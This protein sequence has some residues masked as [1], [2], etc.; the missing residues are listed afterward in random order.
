MSVRS[1]IILYLLMAFNLLAADQITY[2]EKNDL[3][4]LKVIN[5]KVRYFKEL[6]YPGYGIE[7]NEKKAARTEDLDL[8]LDFNSDDITH[9]K[10]LNYKIKYYNI[11]IDPDIKFKNSSAGILNSPA[12]KIVVQITKDNY[13][14]GYI[15]LG[16]FYFDF[17]MLLSQYN[18]ENVILK[19]GVYSDNKFYGAVC[20]I[21]N[22]KLSVRFENFF[23]D[24]AN[25]PY[26]FS[27]T[28]KK[29]I[30]L[31]Q[32]LH[33]GFI[34]DRVNGK[35]LLFINGR[36][37]NEKFATLDQAAGSEILCPR[38]SRFDGSDLVLFENFFGYVD[39]FRIGKTAN[40]DFKQS[41]DTLSSKVIIESPLISF[42]Y[43]SSYISNIV[44]KVKNNDK[45][46]INIY[47][48]Y[49]NKLRDIYSMEWI[50]HKY[51]IEENDIFSIKDFPDI[52]KY[53][54]WRL[55]MQR[56][57]TEKINPLFYYFNIK[58]EKNPPPLPPEDI[59]ISKYNNIFKL[60]W[61][62]SLEK[63]LKGYIIYWGMKSQ[64]YENKVDVGLKN[65][66]IL[67]Y[68]KSNQNY[69]FSVKAYDSTDPYN[70]SE[71]SKEV[72]IFNK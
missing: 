40:I 48:K 65:N 33:V 35:L 20:E 10:T 45:G 27:I 30:E 34:F 32:W 43:I 23:Y 2:K 3:N 22:K 44:F 26:S 36:L 19:K 52:C 28:S 56:N 8:F 16:S 72:H 58:Y 54:K 41:V 25:K 46:I 64:V 31:N 63:D 51:I 49:G 18:T 14:S 37:D 60:S 71:F 42:K 70:L 47:Y 61:K 53:Y 12:N 21:K 1:I 66:Y 15:D 9:D 67:D 4:K 55:E 13:L 38:F 5:G 39:N 50:E 59:R 29:I 69:Y 57:S 24:A 17:F 7:F 62:E 68:L 6:K 11:K